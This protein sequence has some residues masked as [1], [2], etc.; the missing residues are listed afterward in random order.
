MSNSVEIEN[1]ST[2]QY[3]GFTISASGKFHVGIQNLVDKAQRAWFSILKILNKSKHKQVDTYLILF[4]RIIRPI[5]LY[6]CEI[7]GKTV[8]KEIL[9]E[10]GKSLIE[11]FHFKICKQIIGVNKK[12]QILQQ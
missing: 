7:W 10:L 4:D 6:A 12:R 1:V 11:R 3:L 8:N 5:L 9:T 2:Y